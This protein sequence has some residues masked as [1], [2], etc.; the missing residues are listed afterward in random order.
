MRSSLALLLLTLAAGC[1]APTQQPGAPGSAPPGGGAG[2]GGG[3]AGA[4]GP[5][6]GGPG[7]GGGFD[8]AQMKPHKTQEEVKAGPHITVS[9]TVEGTCAGLLRI[10][11]IAANKPGEAP[12][13][14]P[15]PVT[16]LEMA[17]VGP[18]SVLIPQGLSVRV[19]AICDADRDN[20]LASADDRIAEAAD[21]GD[22]KADKSGVTLV[23]AAP[24]SGG[25]G[26]GPGGPG[27]GPGGPP[28]GGE[29]AGG[30][31]PGGAGGPPPGGEGAGGPPSGGAGGPPP[32]G[33][34][35]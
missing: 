21:I 22:A 32:G 16:A 11:V 26:G 19:A 28:P 10:D 29:G 20:K 6:G 18:F 12:S 4:G 14:P 15:G 8:L 13:G 35:K 30:P 25:P 34:P 5:G 27:G 1:P 31:P 23:L 33:P 9:G 24:P 3:G 2:E 17:A 7:A